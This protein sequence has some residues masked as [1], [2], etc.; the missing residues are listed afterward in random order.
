LTNSNN[1]SNNK[2]SSNSNNNNNNQTQQQHLEIINQKWE[3]EEKC[4]KDT[5]MPPTK[6]FDTETKRTKVVRKPFP[7]VKP[8]DQKGYEIFYSKIIDPQTGKPYEQRDSSGSI[9]KQTDGLPPARYIPHTIVRLRSIDSKEYLY[10]LGHLHGFNSFGDHV[11]YY[12]HKPEVYTKTFFDRQR[13][14]DQKEQRVIEVV[15]S[16]NGSQEV[17]TLEFTPENLD[18]L[19]ANTVKKNTPQIYKTRNRGTATLGKPVNLVVKDEQSGTAINVEW[20]SMEKS[21]ELFRNKSFSYLFNAEFI[22]LPL[23]AE[24]R[25]R[26]E[27]ITG[28]K[29]QQ[30]PKVQDNN[31]SASAATNTINNI[32]VYK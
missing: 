8:V 10:T 15:T 14:Y 12:V 19:Y 32:E 6:V 29:I 3:L 1:S 27:G 28:E 4:F 5:L 25:A 9:I 7:R 26:S 17:Y 30:S 20:S 11:I 24:L 16:P 31:N 21:Y 2:N 18:S 22:P 23:K 13:R